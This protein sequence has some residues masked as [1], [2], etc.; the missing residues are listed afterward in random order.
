MAQ[1]NMKLDKVIFWL[2]SELAFREYKETGRTEKGAHY[3]IDKAEEYVERAMQAK[4]QQNK[5]MSC[6]GRMVA[7]R[8][9]GRC[10]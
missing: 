5:C 1:D 6:G 3:W 2:A 4:P 8:C 10:S 7:N 9:K